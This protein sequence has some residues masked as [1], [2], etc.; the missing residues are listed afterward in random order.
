MQIE[1]A[2]FR[3]FLALQRASADAALRCVVLTGAQGH[4]CAGA[5]F[6]GMQE[7]LDAGY[8][9]GFPDL[10]IGSADVVRSQIAI[11]QPVIAAIN[12]DAIGLGATM[13]LFCDI[14]YMAD[15]HVRIGLVAA[16]LGV[17]V[18]PAPPQAATASTTIPAPARA[19]ARSS[20]GW[21]S[22]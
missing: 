2:V 21:L 12:G 19:A 15:P 16:G 17:A 1:A 14:V 11:P 7:N 8:E 18:V 4:F 20:K 3:I 22:S 10:M 9:D 13:A 6:G 5:D